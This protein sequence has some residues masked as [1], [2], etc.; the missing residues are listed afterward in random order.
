MA[1]VRLLVFD[2]VQLWRDC[3]QIHL[4]T[5]FQSPHCRFRLG[6]IGSSSEG[7]RTT[8]GFSSLKH[9]P[10]EAKYRNRTKIRELRLSCKIY[11]SDRFGRTLQANCC[12]VSNL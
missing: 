3:V 10:S 5:L 9:Q 1:I 2:D 6:W 4:G 12:P 7:Q 8:T 11:F